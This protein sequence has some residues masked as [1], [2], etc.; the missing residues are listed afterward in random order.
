MAA[1]QIH[2]RVVSAK[3]A[4]AA[5]VIKTTAVTH[6]MS[7]DAKLTIDPPNTKTHSGG[8]RQMIAGEGAHPSLP[9][10]CAAIEAF[11]AIKHAYR[12]DWP[13]SIR[14]PVLG[15]PKRNNAQT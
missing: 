3:S 6:T 9:C 7:R 2:K 1:S 14:G 10:G 15:T 8:L 4:A 13:Q 5:R 11:E 12:A